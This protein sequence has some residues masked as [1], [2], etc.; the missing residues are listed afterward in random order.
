MKI[1]SDHFRRFVA[2]GATAFF[3]TG[4]LCRFPSSPEAHLQTGES[5]VFIGEEP[6]QLACA[7]LCHRPIEVRSTY[8]KNLPHTVCYEEGRDFIVDDEHGQVRRTTQSRI[9]DFRTNMLFGV[10]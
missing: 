1:I 10:E 5:V 3:L 2:A 4:C 7:P 6:A 8:L 9:P